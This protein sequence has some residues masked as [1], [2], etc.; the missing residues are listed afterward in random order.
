[1]TNSRDMP[2]PDLSRPFIPKPTG[3]WRPSLLA[4]SVL[5]LVLTLP[6][7]AVLASLFNPASQ[8]AGHIWATNGPAYLRGTLILCL[9]VG[10]LSGIVGTVCAVLV[11]LFDLPGRRFFSFAL[12]LPFAVPGYIAAYSYGDFLSPFGGLSTLLGGFGFDPRLAGAL[13]SIRSMPGAIVILSVTVYPYVYLAV[14]AD[15]V[16]RSAAYLEAARSLGAS[17]ARSIMRVLVPGTRTAMLGGLALALMETA[18]DYGVADY[19]GVRTLSTGIFR[20]WYGLGD[21]T[22]AAQLA[23]GL[24]IIAAFLLLLEDSIRRART[25]EPVR[26]G[27]TAR[28]LALRAPGKVLAIVFCSMPIFFGFI[29]PVIILISLAAQQ[30]GLDA[31]LASILR[32]GGNTLILASVSAIA[33]MVLSIILAYAKRQASHNKATQS[34]IVASLIRLMTLGYAIPGAVIAIGILLGGAFILKPFGLSITQGGIFIL[35]FAYIVRFLTAGYNGAHGGLSQISPLMDMAGRS[36]GAHDGRLMTRL[37]LPIARPALIAGAIIVFIDVS[38]EL[39]ATLLLRP[40]N[41]ETLATSV[42][43]LASDERLGAAA[44]MALALILAGLIPVTL[45]SVRE[46]RAG[47]IDYSKVRSS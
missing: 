8:S 16:G 42:Y 26:G 27:R 30:T 7:L 3:P 19:F 35:L 9:G 29:L 28:R 18:A 34:P 1:M 10:V 45:L 40:F 38:R 41:F 23:S 33:V 20:T 25:H 12:A 2:S 46:Q 24:F 14:R 47:S 37:H 21:L 44:P 36:L 5:G 6:V 15:L 32:A 4:L 13:P 17:P 43:R 22:A 39:P 11:S 31:R